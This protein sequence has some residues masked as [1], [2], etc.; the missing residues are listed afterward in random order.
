MSALAS[1]LRSA[2]SFYNG[3]TSLEGWLAHLTAAALLLVPWSSVL[4]GGVPQEEFDEVQDSCS[5]VGLP[6]TLGEVGICDEQIKKD[7]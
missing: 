7:R 4:E 1:V 5:E 3:A 2:H 6:T